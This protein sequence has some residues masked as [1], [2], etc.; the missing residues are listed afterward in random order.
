MYSGLPKKTSPAPPG[1]V[2]R[3]KSELVSVGVVSSVVV[4]VTC[5][6]TRS[7]RDGQIVALEHTFERVVKR[8]IELVER[9]PEGV[10]AVGK[11]GGGRAGLNLGD[12]RM[13]AFA[14]MLILLMIYRPTGLLG[15]RE[16]WEFWTQPQRTQRTQRAYSNT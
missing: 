1:L 2:Q 9:I 10:D 4:R 7:R 3:L 14:L 6:V 8:V 12:Y 13:I 11:V 16:I 15:L 5:I